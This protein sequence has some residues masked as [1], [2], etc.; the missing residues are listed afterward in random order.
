MGNILVIGYFGYVTNQLDGQTIKTRNVYKLITHNVGNSY[1]VDYI[2]T[3]E[4]KVSPLRTFCKL[5]LKPLRSSTIV[6]LPGESNLKKYFPILY[7][8][9]KFARACVIYPVVGGWLPEFLAKNKTLIPKLQTINAVLVESERMRLELKNMGFRNVEILEKFRITDFKPVVKNP[10]QG[11]IKLVFMARIRADKGCNIIF[12]ALDHI[13]EID[14]ISIDF[15]GKINIDYES[16]FKS[17][18]EMYSNVRYC[19][20]VQPSEVFDT[21]SKYDCLLLPTF[22]NGEG[23]PGTIVEAYMAGV[24]VIVSNWKDLA[25]FV[26]DGNNGFVIPPQDSRALADCISYLIENP[27]I[28]S[29]MK[30]NALKSSL[31]FSES[32]AWC[33]INKYIEVKTLKCKPLP[34]PK[35]IIITR[36]RVDYRAA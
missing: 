5:L 7:H 11:H 34:P 32:N 22:Y 33:V 29:P 10:S 3:E 27:K 24:P 12:E 6:Y 21:I 4:L 18:I 20:I 1:I 23:F 8:I 25:S 35:R 9:S 14:N 2:D 28:L 31:K 19:G 16:E 15:Y 17:K 13:Q 26:D 30:E 36:Q